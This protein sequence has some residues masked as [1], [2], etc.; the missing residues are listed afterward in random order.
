MLTT[1]KLPGKRKPR[2]L[3]NPEAAHPKGPLTILARRV[4]MARLAARLTQ[5]LLAQIIGIGRPNLVFIENGQTQDPRTS[6]VTAI[7]K[8]TGVTTD[9]LVGLSDEPRRKERGR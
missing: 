6:I 8:A 1:R 5:A 7:A 3:V 9:Y 2:R 4:R